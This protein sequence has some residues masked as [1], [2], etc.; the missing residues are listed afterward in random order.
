MTNPYKHCPIYETTDFILR[1]VEEED[2]NDLLLCY[3]DPKSQELF[4]IDG[5]PHE[6][7]FL[8]K[9]E[10]LNYIKFWLMEYEQDRYVRFSIVDKAISK[11]IG[12]IE[13]FGGDVGILRV[14]LAS[15]YEK[16]SILDELLSV[17]INNFYDLFNTNCIATKA[18]NKATE[19]ITSLKAVGFVPK[20]FNGKSGYYLRTRG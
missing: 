12:T 5:F 7:K 8:T 10:M 4:N 17:C 20:D 18:I 3:S 15:E 2:A 19:R 14:D 11:A 13:M 6:C 16:Q 1:R 9:E